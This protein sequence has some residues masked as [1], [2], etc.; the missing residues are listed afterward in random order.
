[1]ASAQLLPQPAPYALR[2]TAPGT[3]S[4][5]APVLPRP[6][7]ETE[8]SKRILKQPSSLY[9]IFPIVLY[10]TTKGC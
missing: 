8:T 2:T 1:M 10:K 5:D 6:P 4:P 7:M 3:I 9:T